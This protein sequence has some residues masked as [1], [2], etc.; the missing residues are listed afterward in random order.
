MLRSLF[1]ALSQSARA[2]QLVMSFPL[3]RRFA[4]RFVAGEKLEEAITVIRRL[5]GR[6]LLATFDRL[7]ENVKTADEAIG[8]AD[9]YVRLLDAIEQHR[10]RSNV[11]LKLTQLGLDVDEGLCLQNLRRILD[12]ARRYQNFVRIDMEGSAYTQRTLDTYFQ[13]RAEGYDNVG[14]VIQSY[15]YRSADDVRRLSECGAKV[16]ICK[17]AYSEPP[18]IA[19]PRKADVDENYRRLVE[20]MWSE[21][22]LAKG[23][24]AALATHDEKLI[25]W[26]KDEAARRGIRQD[27][28]E[29][30]MLYGIRRERQVQLA[31]EGYRFRVYVPYGTQWYPYFMRRLGERPAN[32]LFLLKNLF[33]T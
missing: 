4:R 23:A 33:E 11:S 27:Q 22:A 26:A 12:Q 19:Y 32:L 31:N 25:R 18:D 9:D 29:F 14:V 13:L 6:G 28:F 7:G 2:R 21:G 1:V 8:S 3:S 17:G 24:Y 5:N 16:R 20:I 15:L 10:L 30:Q